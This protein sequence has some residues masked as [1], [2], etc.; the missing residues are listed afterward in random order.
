MNI[1]V[2]H[3]TLVRS[4]PRARGTEADRAVGHITVANQMHEMELVRQK[5]FQLEQT[6]IE[7]KQK[8]DP[9]TSWLFHHLALA[10]MSRPH[11]QGSPLTHRS[12]VRQRDL[13]LASRTRCSRRPVGVRSDGRP[14][15]RRSIAPATAVHRPG[16]EQ[17][18]RRHHGRSGRSGWTRLGPAARAAPAATAA[19]AAT[20]SDGATTARGRATPSASASGAAAISGL[21]ARPGRER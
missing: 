2:R 15:A 14:A 13:A 16:T 6:Q 3:L 12:Q 19:A 7:L 10:T 4:W 18:V 11:V 5:V 21:P 9:S 8:Y 1:R 17:R 20:A